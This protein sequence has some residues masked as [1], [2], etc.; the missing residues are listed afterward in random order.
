MTK[1]AGISD[2]IYTDPLGGM[3]PEA[4]VYGL[5]APQSWTTNHLIAVFR[6]QF[7][8]GSSLDVQLIM[9]W[10]RAR[11]CMH[12]PTLWWFGSMFWSGTAASRALTEVALISAAVYLVAASIIKGCAGVYRHDAA[13][14]ASSADHW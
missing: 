9:A 8:N 7:I 3:M 10:K 5:L 14:M 2:A 11:A 6:R 4:C 12:A 13:G 1:S